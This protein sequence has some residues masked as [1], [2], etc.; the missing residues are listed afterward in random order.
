M[1]DSC[2]LS[3]SMLLNAYT[4]TL[5]MKETKTQREVFIAIDEITNTLEHVGIK[6]RQQKEDSSNI[7]SQLKAFLT[8]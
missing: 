1:K 8:L 2:L 6:L 5:E 7:I 4:P 3:T